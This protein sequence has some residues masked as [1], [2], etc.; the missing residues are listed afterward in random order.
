MTGRDPTLNGA[1]E[2][3]RKID[4]LGLAEQLGAK[5]K[6]IASNEWAG[7]CQRAGGRDG[8]SVN[9]RKKIFNCRRC[10]VGGDAIG[11]VEH[12]TGSSFVEAVKFITGETTP[13]T[14]RTLR[15]I[16]TIGRAKPKLRPTPSSPHGLRPSSA[17]LFP[18][19]ALLA[20]FISEK[21]AQSILIRSPTS[22]SES[23][24]SAG[25]RLS[26]SARRRIPSTAKGSAA[27]SPS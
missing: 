25:I 26:Y 21:P 9:A 27:S 8:F 3:A 23:T 16:V 14:A 22:S 11:M 18:S 15:S 17:N 2:Q 5:L 4:I 6:K 24:R 20:S 10:A 12:I 1:I 19:A 7:P 13:N